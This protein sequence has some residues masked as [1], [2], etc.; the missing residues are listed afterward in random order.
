[1]RSLRNLLD[2]IMI[3]KAQFNYISCQHIYMEHNSVSNQLSK[4]ATTHPRG[5]W[6]VQEQHGDENYQYYH[7]P[8]IDRAYQRADRP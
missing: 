6:I 2:E 1:M 7:C 5:L 8:Y 4:V 3:L